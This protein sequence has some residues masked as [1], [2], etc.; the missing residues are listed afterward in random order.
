MLLRLNPLVL[1]K[2]KPKIFSTTKVKRKN[3]ISKVLKSVSIYGSL[4]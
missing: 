2:E 3:E 4:N 1:D